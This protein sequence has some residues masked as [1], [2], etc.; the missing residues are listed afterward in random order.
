MYAISG[1]TVHGIDRVMK[2]KLS[3]GVDFHDPDEL[4]WKGFPVI[5]N[6]DAEVLRVRWNAQDGKISLAAFDGSVLR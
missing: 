6:C 1:K 5:V 4:F 3:V 2:G